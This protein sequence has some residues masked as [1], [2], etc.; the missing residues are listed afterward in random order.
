M[1]RVELN[2]DWLNQQAAINPNGTAIVYEGT[3]INYS[4]LESKAINTAV[5]LSSKEIKPREHVALLCENNIDFVIILFALW[6]LKAIPVPINIFN[7]EEEIYSLTNRADCTSIIIHDGLKSKFNNSDKLKKIFYPLTQFNT[8]YKF[9]IKNYINANNTALILFTS[10]STSSPQGVMLSFSSLYNSAVGVDS[11]V[12]Q[13]ASDRWL[14]SLP[15]YHIGGLS[16]IIRALLAGCSIVFPGSL[17][18]KSIID[19]LI[20]HDPSLISLVPKMLKDLIEKSVEP[21][22]SLRF[23]FLGGSSTDDKL[24]LDSLSNNWPIYKVYGLTETASMVTAIS[25]NELINKLSSSGKPI[26]MNK[27]FIKTKDQLSVEKNI[28]GNIVIS[29]DSIAKGYYKSNVETNA[30]FNGSSYITNDIGFLDDDGYLNIIGREDRIIIS[31]GENINPEEV[32]KI[33]LLHPLI[34]ETTVFG[35]LDKKWGQ[36]VNAA[37]VINKKNNSI[38]NSLNS[39]LKDKIAPYKIPK[40][41][42]IVDSLPKN[43]LGKVQLKK[44]IKFL[45][46]D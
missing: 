41:V 20:I 11:I 10:G 38:L 42:F 35:T 16:I 5:L 36:V 17:K 37:I 44:L 45:K 33:I 13:S 15:L 25:P 27:I 40:R 12:K 22:N 14:V 4:E 43:E 6:K 18:S 9:E 32:E 30:R 24:I 31:G 23:L 2:R 7:T 39:F 8:D 26:L 28:K 1:I 3:T 29:S 19:A 21:N 34:S 46:L